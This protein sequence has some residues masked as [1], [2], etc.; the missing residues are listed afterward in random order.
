MYTHRHAQLVESVGGGGGGGGLGEV[1]LS[2]HPQLISSFQQPQETIPLS[3]WFVSLLSMVSCGF[4]VFSCFLFIY[5]CFLLK[6][7]HSENMMTNV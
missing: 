2:V 3:L 4:M 6:Q 7:G 5:R 1:F